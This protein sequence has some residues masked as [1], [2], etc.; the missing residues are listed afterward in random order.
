M[1]KAETQLNQHDL[2]LR[3]SLD[4]KQAGLVATV[5]QLVEMMRTNNAL[6]EGMKLDKAKVAGLVL[7][8]TTVL[9][10]VYKLFI[11]P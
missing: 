2:A 9:G 8:V 11:A 7:G 6:L 10:L 3:G 4:G 5:N 1:D